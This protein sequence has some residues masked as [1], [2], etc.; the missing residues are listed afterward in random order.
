MSEVFG[1][2]KKQM[3]KELIK[4][5]HAGANPDEV[6]GKFKRHFEG[7]GSPQIAQ[8]E[9]ELIKEGMPAEEVHRLCDV[10]LAVFRES[11]EKQEIEVTLGHPIHTF[12]EEHKNILQ[13]SDEMKAVT[14][15]IKQA[16]DF[17]SV[18]EETKQL[19]HIAEHLMEVEKH[20]LR[21][22]NVL[23]PYLEKHG[24][25][26]PPA[27]M[28]SEHTELRENKKKLRELVNKYN[29]LSFQDFVRQLEEIVPS[30][31]NMLSSHIYKENNI[32][33]PTALATIT[34]DEWKNIKEEC[35]ELGYC[36]FTPQ[37]EN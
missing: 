30:I 28:W 20:Y 15:K 8:I 36:C 34:E 16:K 27:I 5:L 9:D 6:K 1:E 10:H 25:I 12:M 37:G 33:Y 29:T 14:Q 21:E 7:I 2:N 19:K 17:N 35:D 31:A 13:F 11:L 32:L 24:V 23:F 26:G 4:E 18:I 3:L 22:E